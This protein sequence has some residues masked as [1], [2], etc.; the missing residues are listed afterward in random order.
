MKIQYINKIIL[1]LALVGSFYLYKYCSNKYYDYKFDHA[2]ANASNIPVKHWDEPYQNMQI[3]DS[4]RVAIIA[5]DGGGEYSYFEYFKYSAEKLGWQVAIYDGETINHEQAILEFDPDFILYAIFANPKMPRKL[6]I[7][8]SKKYFINFHPLQI[9]RNALKLI[10]KEDPFKVVGILKEEMLVSDGLLIGAKEI[11]ISR[12]TLEQN[13]KKFNGIHLL[14]QVS[15]TLNQTADPKNIIWCNTGWDKLRGSKKYHDFIKLLS[16]NTNFKAYGKYSRLQSYID[17]SN[18]DGFIPN[19]SAMIEAIRKNGIYLLTHSDF[20]NQSTV[21]SL[22]I[23]EAVA[24]NAIVISDKNPFAMKYFGD[25]FLYFDHNADADTMYNQVKVHYDWI[26]A[27]PDKAKAMAARSHQ[28][29]L[30]KFTLEK[31]LVRIAKMHEA[32]LKQEREMH[33]LYPFVY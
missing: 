20:H 2:L 32:I 6:E 5:G 29:F 25:N 30:E 16:K 28:I 1:I 15:A 10:S 4:Y 21:P 12:I 8:R 27:N 19:S 24:A 7:H 9:T 13:H 31:D 3:K 33:L 14:P 23:F 22:R 26:L 18:Y 17:Q 11:D